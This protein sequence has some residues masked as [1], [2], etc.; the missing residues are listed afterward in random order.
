MKIAYGFLLVLVVL[1]GCFGFLTYQIIQLQSQVT[2]LQQQNTEASKTKVIVLAYS[3]EDSLYGG[4]EHRISVN[5]TL[6][7]VNSLSLSD[8]SVDIVAQFGN[9]TDST[10]WGVGPMESWQTQNYYDLGLVYD[11]TTW[12]SVNAV[13]L[14]I[15]WL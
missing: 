10:G 15:G 3:W 7:N 6:L 5:C 9:R 4:S 2:T 14:E 8:V 1:F 13:W 11:K 12:G